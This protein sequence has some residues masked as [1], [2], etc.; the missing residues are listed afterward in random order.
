MA[1]TVADA[2]VLLTVLAAADPAD[3][4]TTSAL[5]P[6]TDFTSALDT[7]S[8]RG[9]RIGVIRNRLFG[10]SAAADRLAG[11]A[12]EVMHQQGA[13]IVDPVNIPTLGQFDESEFEVLLYEFKTDLPRFFAW[14]GPGAPVRSVADLIAFN[15]SHAVE[16]LPHFGQEILT[17]AAGKGA[18]TDAAYTAALTKAQRLARVQGLDAAMNRHRLDALVAPTGGPAWLTDLING[19]SGTATAPAPSSI[20]AVAGYPH[21]TVP[22]GFERGLPLGLS[23]IGRA[24]S[25]PTLI[26]IAYAYEQAT[27]H[28]RPPTF[29]P[30]AGQ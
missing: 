18:L 14:W 10:S 23:F 3:A 20:A 28:R 16:E 2:A 24:W 9:K 8:L 26:G 19:D 30:T 1:R 27:H 25:E 6:S 12:I 15:S 11:D 7:G 5:R 29:A 4:P 22:M 13:V 17:M 21:I